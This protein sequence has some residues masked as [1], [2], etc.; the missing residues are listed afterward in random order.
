MPAFYLR[1]F[2]N[3]QNQLWVRD[4]RSPMPGLRKESDLAIRDFYTFQNIHGEPDGRMEQVLQK[5][6]GNAA[7]AL[8]RVTSSVTWGRPITPE[9]KTDLCVFTAFQY[10]RGLRKRRE[11]DPAYQAARS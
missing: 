3:S 11:I 7:S 9:D 1:R 10:V 8:R 4:R 2:A 6:E 5:I